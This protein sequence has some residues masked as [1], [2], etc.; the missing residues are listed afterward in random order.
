MA[1]DMA[2][3]IY[4]TWTEFDIYGSKNL[5][6]HSRI[7]FFT[8]DVAWKDTFTSTISDVA[9]NCADGDSTPEGATIAFGQ[10]DEIFCAWSAFGNIYIDHSKNRGKY[11]QQNRFR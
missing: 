5:K 8:T 10:N 4:I 1:F 3:N 7:R 9:G 2:D 6:D 11:F